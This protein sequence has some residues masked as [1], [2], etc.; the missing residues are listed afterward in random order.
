MPICSLP[1]FNICFKKIHDETKKNT[2]MN[3]GDSELKILN[4][5]N[6]LKKVRTNNLRSRV[7]NPKR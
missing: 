4:Q 1:R 2:E 5:E 7:V 3:L 6:K